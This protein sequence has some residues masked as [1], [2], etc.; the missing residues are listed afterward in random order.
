MVKSLDQTCSPNY[1]GAKMQGNI[2]H[3][4]KDTSGD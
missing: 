2:P 4:Y 1:E 3:N